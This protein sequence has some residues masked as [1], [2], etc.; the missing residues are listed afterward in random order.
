MRQKRKAEEQQQQQQEQTKKPKTELPPEVAGTEH[1]YLRQGNAL[2]NLKSYEAGIV[3]YDKAIE[4]NPSCAEAYNHKGRALKD[5]GCYREAIEVYDKAISI[6]PDFARAYFCK[7][8]VLYSLGRYEDAIAACNEAIRIKPYYIDA[9]YSKSVSLSAL[10]RYHDSLAVCDEAISMQP[11]YA[12]A[13]YGRGLAL[14]HLGRYHDALASYNEVIRIKPD[15]VLAYGGKGHSLL[16]IADTGREAG[17]L[18]A[19]EN[20]ISDALDSFNKYES[21]ASGDNKHIPFKQRALKLLGKVNMALVVKFVEDNPESFFTDAHK[22]RIFES[23]KPV[24]KTYEQLRPENGKEFPRINK[25]FPDNTRQ[26]DT[27]FKTVDF[28]SYIKIFEQQKNRH[29]FEL[30][31]ICKGHTQNSPFALISKDISSEIVSFLDLDDINL[32]GSSE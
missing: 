2:C 7:N 26:L 24:M 9:V 29:F 12:Y 25:N 1:A 30:T 21:L 5:L 17:G 28:C 19:V 11:D 10:R 32:L 31:G 3:S 16:T 15:Y 23:Y 8:L 22:M 18:V 4:I 14:G 13:W 27:F 20:K 6:R